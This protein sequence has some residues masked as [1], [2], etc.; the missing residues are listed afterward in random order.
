MTYLE[1]QVREALAC[2]IANELFAYIIGD[3]ECQAKITQAIRQATDYVTETYLSR[4]EKKIKPIKKFLFLS[5]YENELK[6]GFYRELIQRALLQSMN[7]LISSEELSARLNR[8]KRDEPIPIG[9]GEYI[10]HDKHEV[11]TKKEL[12][13][14]CEELSEVGKT[15]DEIIRRLVDRT[16]VVGLERALQEEKAAIREIFPISDQYK[17]FV[18]ALWKTIPN[19]GKIPTGKKPMGKML[20]QLM[21]KLF[22]ESKDGFLDQRVKQIYRDYNKR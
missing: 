2:K 1:E 7:L 4:V 3:K 15:N 9:G 6:Q 20:D 16:K 12:I 10:P 5:E 14:I 11:K 21:I 22:D 8:F 17:A 19:I 18:T 13:R